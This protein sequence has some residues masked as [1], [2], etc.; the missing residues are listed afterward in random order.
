MRWFRGGLYLEQPE[1]ARCQSSQPDDHFC[2]EEEAVE[3]GGGGDTEGGHPAGG[4][5]G[6][7]ERSIQNLIS[8]RHKCS[9]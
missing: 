5:S 4:R 9:H 3:E 7:L 8:V 6:C 1:V 2:G